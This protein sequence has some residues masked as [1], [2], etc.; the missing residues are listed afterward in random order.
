MVCCAASG[1]NTGF[2]PLW[3]GSSL[4]RFTELSS[5]KACPCRFLD[6]RVLRSVAAGGR[7]EAGGLFTEASPPCG[8]DLVSESMRPIT[9]IDCDGSPWFARFDGLLPCL[10]DE[11]GGDLRSLSPEFRG[12]RGLIKL[13][14]RFL[15]IR[16]LS[17]LLAEMGKS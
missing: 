5:P 10:E 6:P 11:E 4:C 7:P 14:S 9:D 2:P 15:V 16:M 12:S 1:D 13:S 8:R 17:F 3:V